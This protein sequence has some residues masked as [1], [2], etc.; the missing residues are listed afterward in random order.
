MVW[1]IISLNVEHSLAANWLCPESLCNPAQNKQA[2]K[3]KSRWKLF[4][5]ICTF[6]EDIMP[7]IKFKTETDLDAPLLRGCLG[8]QHKRQLHRQCR[9]CKATSGTLCVPWT[10]SWPEGNSWN[11]QGKFPPTVARPSPVFFHS[12]GF[13]QNKEFLR[14]IKLRE[15]LVHQ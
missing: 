8:R 7:Q 2:E 11:S 6:Q 14:Y 5:H 10:S 1:R 12:K 15:N 3:R 13:R 4:R 9:V